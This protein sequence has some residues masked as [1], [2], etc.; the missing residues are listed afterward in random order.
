MKSLSIFTISTA[1]AF[2]V[3]LGNP[4]ALAQQEIDPDHFDSPNREPNRQPNA[5]DSKARVIRYHGTFSLPYSVLCNGKKLTPGEYSISLRSNGD[6]GQTTLTQDGHAVERA[7]VVRRAA[8][9][10]PDEVVVEDSKNG[11]TLSVVRVSGFDFVFDPKHLAD[12]SPESRPTR[13]EKLPLT[14][15]APNEIANRAPSRAS[16]KP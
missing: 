6:V 10:Q 3:A 4:S 7:G 1:L 12:R 11:R 9:K 2:L 14:M 8:Y 15:V 16:T 13:V 5:A